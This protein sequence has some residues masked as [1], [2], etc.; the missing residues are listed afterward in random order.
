MAAPLPALG[1]SAGAGLIEGLLLIGGDAEGAAPDDEPGGVGIVPGVAMT[2]AVGVGVALCVAEGIGD[3]VANGAP[4]RGAAVVAS[5]PGTP[6]DA[7][8]WGVVWP[9]AYAAVP[10]P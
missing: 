1:D 5:A 3:G 7:D 2:E 8:G 10:I 6:G 9:P 4:G